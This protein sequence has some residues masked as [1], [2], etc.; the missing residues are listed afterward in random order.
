MLLMMIIRII[1]DDEEYDP[2]NQIRI[3]VGDRVVV[4]MVMVRVRSDNCGAD[5]DRMVVE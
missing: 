4:A 3:V 2:N 5:G 1:T